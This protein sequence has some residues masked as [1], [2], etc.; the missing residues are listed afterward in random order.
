MGSSSF[1]GCRI[2]VVT[3]AC[4]NQISGSNIRIRSDLQSCSTIP[5]TIMIVDLPVSLA[6]VLSALPSLN[7]LPMYTTKSQ[8]NIQLLKSIK[9][10]IKYLSPASS[11]TQ[12][13]LHEIA[14]PVALKMTAMKTSYTKR[15]NS[16][17]DFKTTL[18]L[19]ITSFLISMALHILITFLY[20]KYTPIR[21]LF[22]S[23]HKYPV[24]Q[25]RLQFNPILTVEDDHFQAA[26]SHP[27]IRARQN[28]V[29]SRTQAAI[30]LRIPRPEPA[31]GSASAP[32][33]IS[34]DQNDY[35][36]VTEV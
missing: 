4:W 34:S 25:T 9:D 18:F 27:K 35:E 5:P 36:E 15:F 20:H 23:T 32:R 7:E 21:R 33:G 3:L 8:A 2:C 22:H 1:P 24:N 28:V 13:A 26:R 11:S 10:N 31:Q 17:A 16:F 19:G 14:K 29:L 30:L 12:D 6:S